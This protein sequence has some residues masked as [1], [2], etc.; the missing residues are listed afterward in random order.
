MRTWVVNK[1][2]DARSRLWFLPGLIVLFEAALAEVL[3]WIDST[4]GDTTGAAGSWLFSGSA[5]AARTLLSAIAGSLLTVVSIAFSLTMIALQQASSQF[6][7]R[8][9]RGFTSSL[10]NQLVIGAYTGTFVYSLLVLRTVRS[11]EQGPVFVPGLAVTTGVLLALTCMGLLVFFIHQV[12]LALQVSVVISRL[13]DDLLAQLEGDHPSEVG[14]R[15]AAPDDHPDRAAALRREVAERPHTLVRARRGG[16]VRGFDADRLLSTGEHADA[17]DPL[18]VHVRAG[19]GSFVARGSVIAAV[20]PP[21]EPGVVEDV[22][23]SVLLADERTPPHDPL[24]VVQQLVDVGL[25]ALSPST[26]DPTTAE[27]VLLHLGDA[28]GT[29]ADRDLEPPVRTTRDGRLLLLLERPDWA[30]HVDA[31]FSQL[32]RAGAS[33]VSVTL[34]L[35]EVL[36][37]LG[38]RVPAG[39]VEPLLAQV[40]QVLEVVEDQPWTVEDR[41][42]VHER[43]AELAR[44]LAAGR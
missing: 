24:F 23:C 8:I 28:L 32:R 14:Q 38:E 13:R 4:Y 37:F 40:Q 22:R 1:W 19:V 35:L 17:D 5:D 18:L 11:G 20:A 42:Q 6:S 7:P 30:G 25:R 43:A 21:P 31:A 41:R 12:S 9:L 2:E 34:R 44:E 26:N 16:F 33:H 27:H 39:R 15:A 3:V 29:L 10:T 36:A